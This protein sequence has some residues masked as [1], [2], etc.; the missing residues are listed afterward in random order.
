MSNNSEILTDLDFEA[1]VSLDLYN[2]NKLGAVIKIITSIIDD[3]KMSRIKVITLLNKVNKYI[4]DVQS[5]M[6]VDQVYQKL[7]E[8]R[9][10]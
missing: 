2:F 1:E 4:L 6:I 7:H 9:E 5:D 10:E 8:I 3:N